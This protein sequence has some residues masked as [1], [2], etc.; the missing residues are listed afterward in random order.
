[1]FHPLPPRKALLQATLLLL[2]VEIVGFGVYA[3]QLG[4]YHDDWPLLEQ[5]SSAPGYWA[6]VKMQT[7]TAAVFRLPQI[8]VWPLVY[9]GA[10]SAPL[11]HHLVAMALDWLGAVALY[12]L[13]CRLLGR[14]R[15]AL[16]AAAFAILHPSHPATHHW[17]VNA[18]CQPPAQALALASLILFTFWLEARARAWL[19]AAAAAYLLSL[20]WYESSAFLPLMLAPAI[21]EQ[22]R[23]DGLR[24]GAAAA[25]TARA[26]APL[27]APLA[28]ALAI[29]SY[30]LPLLSGVPHPKGVTLSPAWTATVLRS[31][32]ESLT[33]ETF[34]LCR[35]TMRPA[36]AFFTDAQSILWALFTF[37]VAAA[38]ARKDSKDRPTTLGRATWVA[39][40]TFLGAYAPYALSGAYEPQIVGIMSRTNGAGALAGALLLAALIEGLSESAWA[41]RLIPRRPLGAALTAMVIGAFTWTDWYIAHLWAEAWTV[42]NLIVAGIDTRKAALPPDAFVLLKAPEHL[43]G[44]PLFSA[45][46]DFSSALRLKTGRKDLT[47][48]ILKAGM[49]SEK[50]GVVHRAGGQVLKVYPYKDLF[51]YSHEESRLYRLTP[52]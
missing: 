38:L 21:L 43:N 2:I 48:D 5:M 25:R 52:P 9:A 7:A 16:A 46:W 37:A 4:F 32:L 8:L 12:L 31:G 14:P 44:A 29:Q 35:I 17:W 20:L 3:R 6:R 1:M 39:L 30:V 18:S 19:A 10:G 26:L 24:W 40:A 15:L 33:L 28:A 50:E 51:M 22:A 42:Q 45:A 34:K 41:A 49:S 36:F 23:R 47:G 11:P 13:L 27:A